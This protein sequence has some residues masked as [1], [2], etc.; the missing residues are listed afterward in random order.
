MRKNYFLY[1]L[2]ITL[3]F[4]SGRDSKAENPIIKDLPQASLELVAESSNLW[5]GVSISRDGR[6]FVCFPR[7]SRQVPISVGEI[8]DG[9][10][11]P[12][13]DQGWNSW[14]D[15]ER[16][17]NKFVCIQSV[18]VDDDDYLWI[19]DPASPYLRGVVDEGARIY[20]F[21]LKGNS[22]IRT[23]SIPSSAAPQKSYLNDIRVDTVSETAYITESGLGAIVIVDLK[24]GNSYR[25]LDNHFSTKAELDRIIIEGVPVE[26]KIHAD[27]IS[28][29]PDR[30][31]LYYQALCARHL[32]KV[33]TKDLREPSI[34]DVL[35]E[36]KVERAGEV[37]ANDGILG[38]RYG[39]IFLSGLET[40]SINVLNTKNQL[41]RIIQDRRIQ[42]PDTFAMDSGGDVYFT[43]SHLHLPPDPSNPYKIFRIRFYK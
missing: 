42:W 24:S 27:G 37:G 23:Y 11:T 5:T 43:V 35:L 22:L 41:I 15:G 8:V 1:L 29:S 25:R 32:Y 21:E 18:V 3:A 26:A 20:K 2:V 31:Y 6:I 28:L 19:L 13:P 17:T 16:A 38:D 4:C 14:M 33:P 7:W 39:N 34:Q 36:S 12:F 9:V 10:V 40:N 30:K